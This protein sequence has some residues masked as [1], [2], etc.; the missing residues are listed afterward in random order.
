MFISFKKGKFLF[1]SKIS[2]CSL[3][4]YLLSCSSHFQIGTTYRITICLYLGLAITGDDV[5]MIAWK[6]FLLIICLSIQKYFKVHF[7]KIRKYF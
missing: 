7:A 4:L 2:F 5:A 3:K 6:G 1:L